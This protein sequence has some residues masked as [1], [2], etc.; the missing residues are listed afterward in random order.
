M[1]SENGDEEGLPWEGKK[2]LPARNDA[3]D[4]GQP[5]P[6]GPGLSRYSRCTSAVRLLWLGE[7][8]ALRYFAMSSTP[9]P[10]DAK[11][12]CKRL[13]RKEKKVNTQQLSTRHP[14]AFLQTWI[15]ELAIVPPKYIAVL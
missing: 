4:G 14:R 3:G 5:A 12:L 7:E 8:V 10:A 1:P 13:T 9:S 2:K 15:S 11:I 6:G